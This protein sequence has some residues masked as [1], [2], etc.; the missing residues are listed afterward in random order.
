[1]CSKLS[2]LFLGDLGVLVKE[3]CLGMHVLPHK[4]ILPIPQDL[5]ATKR[6]ARS[7]PF[8]SL[9]RMTKCVRISCFR[10]SRVDTGSCFQVGRL[11]DT[12][13]RATTLQMH[14]NFLLAKSG[15][16]DIPVISCT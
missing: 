7:R 8:L 13:L 10:A 11:M 4:L 12:R 16:V 5:L 3:G 6:A 1:M 15:C 2:P 9:G 14:L